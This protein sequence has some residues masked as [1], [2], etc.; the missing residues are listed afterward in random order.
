MCKA[1]PLCAL[2]SLFVISSHLHSDEPTPA[3]PPS[4]STNAQKAPFQPFTGK[5]TRNNVRMR[6][7]PNTDCPIV[8]ELNHHDMII[9]TGEHEDFYAVRPSSDFKGYVFRTYV[10]DGVIEGKHVNVR[11]EPNTDAPVLG[12]LNTGDKVDGKVSLLNSKWMEIT[13]PQQIQFYICKEYVEN[14]GDATVMQALLQREEQVEELLLNAKELVGVEMQKPFENINYSQVS[15]SLQY[16]I[17]NY[18]DFPEHVSQ[19][20]EQLAEVQETY[21]HKKLAYLEHKTSEMQPNTE[22]NAHVEI[23][24]V[25]SPEIPV[26]VDPSISTENHDKWIAAENALYQKWQANHPGSS[27]EDF[28]AQQNRQSVVIK[29]ILEPYS[30]TIR[31]KPGDFILISKTTQ[32]PTAYLYSTKLDLKNY[33]GQEVTLRVISRPNHNFAFPAYFVMAL[34]Q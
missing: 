20:K 32:M 22:E 19:A 10:L 26:L 25:S 5:I 11:L 34:E 13:L 9:V 12:Q 27:L 2:A 28:Y 6:L 24:Q 23:A 3:S 21:L 15:A 31:N 8:K 30:R 1:I 4:L 7:Q 18:E 14:I 17:N 29:G 33:V 16:I